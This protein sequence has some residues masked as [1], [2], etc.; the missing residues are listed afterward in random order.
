MLSFTF[1][2]ISTSLPHQWDRPLAAQAKNLGLALLFPTLATSQSSK[3]LL[4]LQDMSGIKLL[5][6]TN[7]HHSQPSCPWTTTV[8]SKLASLPLCSLYA[9]QQLVVLLRYKSSLINP[10]LKSYCGFL[11]PFHAE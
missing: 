10:L 2:A 6:T 1:M 9:T 7:H 11:L 5:L 4:Y 3:K 8:A